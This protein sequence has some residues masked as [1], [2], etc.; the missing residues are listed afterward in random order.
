MKNTK[1]IACPCCGEV[2][3]VK[4]WSDRSVG[5]NFEFDVI[6][7]QSCFCSCDWY[8]E[9]FN[10]TVFEYLDDKYHAEV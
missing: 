10:T 4:I 5:I 1:S 3:T 6:A 9:S 2:L 7:D 8:D